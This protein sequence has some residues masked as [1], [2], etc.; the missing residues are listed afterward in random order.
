MTTPLSS[1]ILFTLD[2]VTQKPAQPFQG[3]LTSYVGSV[4]VHVIA[5]GVVL[6]M[7]YVGSEPAQ[8]VKPSVASKHVPLYFPSP[9]R[10]PVVIAHIQAPKPLVARVKPMVVPPKPVVKVTP[11]PK[12]ASPPPIIAEV[13]PERAPDVTAQ[14]AP[15]LRA[16]VA[17]PAPATKP[18]E[19]RIVKVG[20]FGDPN[21]VPSKAKAQTPTL[22]ATAGGFD[23]PT[24]TG[25][26]RAGGKA[27][28]GVVRA[29]AFGDGTGVTGSASSGSSSGSVRAGGFGDGTVAAAPVA[30][31]RPV[32]QEPAATPLQILSKPK[33]TYTQA[34]REKKIEGV[35]E[36]EVLF[37]ATGEV[38]V[39]R[40]VRGLGYGLDQAAEQVASQIRFRPGTR[41]GVAV[42]SKTIVHVTFEL[43]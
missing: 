10:K 42:D 39:L 1:A 11:A 31:V 21:G 38:Q 37:R 30:R 14:P 34:A 16:T 18:A 32:S 20:G 19:V 24:G 3:K 4:A 41:D 43:T 22:L 9:V 15:I 17:P 13:V 23:M 35:V 7:P 5:L 12:L 25:S 27:G 26:E 6:A 33:P 8:D 40:V 28:S 2:G 36:L 29:S